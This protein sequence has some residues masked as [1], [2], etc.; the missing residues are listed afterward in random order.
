M[1][2]VAQTLVD[3]LK[4]AIE[5]KLKAA[6]SLEAESSALGQLG[7]W[8]CDDRPR[9]PPSRSRAHS[10][11]RAPLFMPFP[12]PPPLFPAPALAMPR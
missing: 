10:I 7:S 3:D 5:Q 4:A 1:Q 12:R 9:P 6:S 11:L 2:A 8:Y